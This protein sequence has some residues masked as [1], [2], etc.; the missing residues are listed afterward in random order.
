M[1]Q[2]CLSAIEQ[3]IHEDED[4]ENEGRTQG[5]DSQLSSDALG[6]DAEQFRTLDQIASS[7]TETR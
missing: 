6:L 7:E 3:Q 4:R 5:C 1:R 2:Y